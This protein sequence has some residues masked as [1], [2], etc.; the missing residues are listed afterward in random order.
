MKSSGLTA[1]NSDVVLT[2]LNPG[3]LL[4]FSEEDMTATRQSLW[5]HTVKRNKSYNVI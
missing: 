2:P 4:S 3:T 5:F 1:R